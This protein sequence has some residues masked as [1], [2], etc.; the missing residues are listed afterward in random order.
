MFPAMIRKSPISWTEYI[1]IRS[2]TDLPYVSL[3]K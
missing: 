1:T 2:E 3:F